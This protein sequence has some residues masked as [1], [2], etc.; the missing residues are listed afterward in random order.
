MTQSFIIHFLLTKG[1][2]SRYRGFYNLVEVLSYS[3]A[4]PDRLH[5]VMDIYKATAARSG[6]GAANIEHNIRY[7]MEAHHIALGL[8]NT[9]R[10]GNKSVIRHLT[11][12][13]LELER[14]L[15]H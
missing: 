15:F 9:P 14:T 12:E 1:Y 11:L 5:S 6:T 7:L 10:A 3:T 8:G 13:L 2:S 4:H